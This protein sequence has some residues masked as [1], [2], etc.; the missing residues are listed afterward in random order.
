MAASTSANSTT[1]CV[2]HHGVQH[3]FSIP[4]E[5][6]SELAPSKDGFLSAVAASDQAPQ[7]PAELALR[8]I[9]H[10]LN[11]GASAQTTAALVAAFEKDFLGTTDIHSLADG[12][13]GGPRAGEPL[14]KTYYAALAHCGMEPATVPSALLTAAAEGRARLLLVFGGQ[15]MGNAGCVQELQAL[16]STYAPLLSRLMGVAAPLL[17]GLCR[18]PWTRKLYA[19]RQID[20]LRWLRHPADVPDESFVASACVSLP[21]IGLVSLAHYAIACAALNM[22]PGQFRQHLH[23]ITGHSQG[24]IVAAGLAECDS[25]ESFY[26][27]ASAVIITLFWS[28]FEAHTAAPQS[29]LSSEEIADCIENGEGRPSHMLSL[30]GLRE[31]QVSELLAACNAHL[32]SESQLHVALQNTADNCVI[33]GPPRSLRGLCLHL[34]GIK[35]AD[36]EDQSRIPHRQRKKAIKSAFLPISAPFHTPYLAAVGA[37]L[38]EHTAG[39]QLNREGAMAI[40]TYHTLAGRDMR[41]MGS[42]TDALADAVANDRV[43]WPATL[44][45]ATTHNGA[46]TH[47]VVLSRGFGGLVASALQG[48]GIVV[49]NAADPG[50][51]QAQQ[52]SARSD[53]FAPRLPDAKLAGHGSWQ[54]RYGPRLVRTASGAAV[55]DTK[56]SRVLGVPPVV[57]AGMTPTTVHWDVVAAIMKAGYH[58]ELAGGGYFEPTSMEAAIEKAAQ[59][60]PGR[61]ITVNLIYASPEAM[62]WQISLLGRLQRRR[63]A[64]DGLAIGA[65]VPSPEIAS[66]YITTLGLRHLALK[67]GSVDAIKQTLDIAAAHPRFPIILQWTG[68]RGG[69]HH[70]FE[71]FHEPILA[72]YAQIRKH[73]NVVLV[74]GSG[75][76]DAAGAYP[77]LTGEW[78]RRFGMPP[79]P[80]DGILLGSRL[81]VAREAHTAAQSKAL[82]IAAPGVEHEADWDRSYEGPAGGVVTVKSEMGQPI[83]KLATRGVLLWAELDRTVFSLPRGERPAALAGMR[84]RL[85][86]RL[87]ADFQKPWFGVD[88]QGRA[89][90][91]A[92]M[93]YAGV[94]ARLMA[95]TFVADQGRWIDRSYAALVRDVACRTLE[96]LAPG[97][98]MVPQLELEPT[99]FVDEFVRL[100]PQAGEALVSPEDARWFVRRCK[101]RDMKPVNFIPALDE[102]FEFFFK[103]DSLWQSEDVDA[104]VG[105]DA[106]RVCILQSPVSVRHSRTADQSVKE[107][108]DE[109]TAGLVERLERDLYGGDVAKMPSAVESNTA[110]VIMPTAA[111]LAGVDITDLGHSIA[112]KLAPGQA[113]PSPDDW[114]AFMEQHTGGWVQALVADRF[115]L[116]GKTRVPNTFRQVLQLRPGER[117]ECDRSQSAIRITTIGPSSEDVCTISASGE[118]ITASFS[119]PGSPA[120]MLR[121]ELS[122]DPNRKDCRLSE[123]HSSRLQHV[124]EMYRSLW[125][126]QAALPE[127]G[128]LKSEFQGPETTITE[129]LVRDLAC[130]LNMVLPDLGLGDAASDH[131]PLDLC[132]ALAW[133][134]L[135]EPLLLPEMEADI[136]RLVHRSNRFE[137][138]PGAKP[139]RVGDK[140]RAVS[141]IQAVTIEEAGKTVAVRAVIHRVAGDEPVVAVT[142]EF[143]FR[144]SSSNPAATFEHIQHPDFTLHVASELEEALLLNRPWFA[145]DDAATSTPLVGRTLLFTNL[146]SSLSRNNNHNGITTPTITNLHTTGTVLASS[147]SS[148][149][150]TPIATISFTTP[151]CHTNPI[152]DFLTRRATTP[153]ATPR[154]IIPLAKPGWH[155]N[156]NNNKHTIRIPAG[157]A[158]DAAYA[159]LSRD[160][161]PIHVAPAVAAL[162]GLPPAPGGGSGGAGGGGAGVVVHGM[163]TSAMARAVV[164]RAALGGGGTADGGGRA[165][166]RAWEARFVGVVRPG[167]GLVVGFEHV[168]M[169]AGAGDQG[170]G[171]GGRGGGGRMVLRVWV[172]REGE[173]GGE[174]ELVMEAE[175]EVEQA[176]T[177]YVFTGQGSQRVGMGMEL[178]ASSAVA[179]GVWD[180]AEK[181]LGDKYGWSMLDIV[182][183]NPK[184][185]TVHFRGPRGRRIRDNYRALTVEKTL[186]DGSTAETPILPG[187]TDQSQSYTFS[188][189]RGLLFSTQFAQPAI[190]LLE[191]AAFEDM[192]AKGLVQDEGA[193][194]AGHSLGEY[195]ALV[196]VAGLLS[197][198][199]AVE[200]MFYRGLTMQLALERNEDGTSDYGMVAVS[201]ARV[202]P[203]FDETA[204]RA[205]VDLIAS[206]ASVLLEVVNLNVRGEQYVC[207]GTLSTLH[208]LGR[209]LDHLAQSADSQSVLGE[210]RS[211]HASS[212]RCLIKQYLAESPPSPLRRGKATIPLQGIDIPFHSSLLRTGVHPYRRFLH[213]TI[214]PVDDARLEK[215]R[216]RYIPNVTAKPFSLADE[217]IRDACDT[218]QSPVLGQVLASA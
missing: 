64:I 29:R 122:Y 154:P 157:P 165:R 143:L 90:D 179:R 79:M 95:L 61:G 124:R 197:V 1:L 41:E 149:S 172:R 181:W 32:P 15:G 200:T 52:R 189:P 187:L 72:T 65:G 84:T 77:Y 25:W 46:I 186:S 80:F 113:P 43:D 50:A 156:N 54:Q 57:A 93:T 123:Q 27:V 173:E 204:L 75:F 216:G 39:T 151:T 120:A 2:A 121:L 37:R 183:T 190:V 98:A 28:G 135:V 40:P 66:E 111:K 127:A 85:I 168:G 70:S 196:A 131:V 145:L 67:P 14:I 193:I 110:E 101:A 112:F 9:Q 21:V 115:I 199:Q 10:L 126:P 68:G 160:A 171:G 203:G 71:D 194:F 205:V 207:A 152:L 31:P 174:G 138:L 180:R 55:L 191:C 162:A 22:T 201:P 137:Y 107:V 217:Y 88:G 69:G 106:G 102:D 5:L 94:L 214:G 53:L 4:V 12:Q 82:I 13:P 167:E 185:L 166:F 215:L 73:A 8:F 119:V 89:V 153:S 114:S 209:L 117:V 48:T 104:V 18:H 45:A 148:S 206:E 169:T 36:D 132:I 35:A 133:E 116:Q 20:L 134:P 129:Q 184:T 139:L 211:G 163:L 158:T 83:H 118:T 59:A 147:P 108:L 63:V 33:G 103:R 56:L 7:T 125:T 17:S 99:G 3:T 24:L 182:K 26:A 177:A 136:L 78:A 44:A 97:Q 23:G 109:I 16:H 140:V 74:A 155:T 6:F 92:D 178:Y 208:C 62:R 47:A 212:L 34:R 76:G 86:E 176:R 170:R 58:G 146:A 144:G 161:N 42:V 96:R 49:I 128:R 11:E 159:A 60:Q 150:P 198:E 91:V 130:T 210:L 38:K 175:A 192:R 105:R 51:P 202:A 195:G 87:N 142:S 213:R 218:T 100:C 164:E 81:M 188:D 141:R 30:R 19:G